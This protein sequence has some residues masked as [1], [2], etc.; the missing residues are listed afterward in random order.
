MVN[1]LPHGRCGS[2]FQTYIKATYLPVK[3]P[4][5]ECN[6]GSRNGLVPSDTS[7]ASLGHSGLKLGHF[8]I[9]VKMNTH[10]SVV[11]GHWF[12]I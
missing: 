8:R 11:D 7:V 12:H 6:T 2:N 4:W 10:I 5:G 9:F 3:S 1:S